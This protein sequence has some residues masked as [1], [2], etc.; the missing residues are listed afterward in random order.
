[1]KVNCIK[2]IKKRKIDGSE[3][4]VWNFHRKPVLLNDGRMGVLN[5]QC[6]NT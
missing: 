5:T 4:H 3:C 6:M 1:M 2:W